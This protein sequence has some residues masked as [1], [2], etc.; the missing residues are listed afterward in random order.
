MPCETK[1][2]RLDAED[3]RRTLQLVQA[4]EISVSRAVEVLDMWLAGRYTDDLL[5]PPADCLPVLNDDRII[6]S[7]QSA[8]VEFQRFVDA[9]GREV[10]W[11]SGSQDASLLIDGVRT[12]L[13]AQDQASALL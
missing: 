11:T 8:G 9:R 1:T 4:G 6:A 5:P 7:F 12:V 13:A 3:M 10:H 2:H